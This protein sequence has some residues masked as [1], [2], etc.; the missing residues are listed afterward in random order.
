[1]LVLCSQ[2]PQRLHRDGA[3]L[4]AKNRPHTWLHPNA[5]Q[6]GQI[7]LAP[8]CKVMCEI[9]CRLNQSMQHRR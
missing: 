9:E 6:K 5:S 8:R 7:S 4:Y 2:Q 3:S 1:M